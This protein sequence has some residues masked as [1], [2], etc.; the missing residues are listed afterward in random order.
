MFQ[1]WEIL[2]HH[3]QQWLKF[4]NGTSRDGERMFELATRYELK[5]HVRAPTRDGHLLDLFLSSSRCY[6]SCFTQ[7]CRSCRCARKTSL[8]FLTAS[9]NPENSMGL[10]A[11]KMGTIAAAVCFSSMAHSNCR[12]HLRS[13]RAPCGHIFPHPSNTSPSAD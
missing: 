10:Q 13:R 1:L 12:W 7:T 3:H 9:S 4:S 8:L 2:N 6:R 11:R 5:E